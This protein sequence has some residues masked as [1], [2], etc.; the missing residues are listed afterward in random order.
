MADRNVKLSEFSGDVAI[1]HMT[2]MEYINHVEMSRIAGGWTDAVTAEKVKLRLTGAARTWLQN[3]IRAE[4]PGLAA[5]DPPIAN[6]VKPPGL[7]DLMINRFMPQQTAGEQERLRATLIQGENESAQV[8]FDRVESIQFIL[9]LELPEV[10]RRESKAN[11]DIVHN[12][13]VRGSFIA[14]LKQE[15]RKHVTTMDVVTLEDALQ[16][17]VAFEK[18][19]APNKP[20][21]AIS[22]ATGSELTIEARLAALELQRQH[23]DGGGAGAGRGQGKLADEGCFYCGYVGH[24][25]QSCR[26]RQADESRGIFQKRAVGYVP[27]R[28]GRGRGGPQRGGGQQRGGGFQPGRGRGFVQFRGAG[29]YRGGRGGYAHAATEPVY[30]QTQQPNLQ[31]A[32]QTGQVGQPA[33]PQPGF[34]PYHGWQQAP[35]MHSNS[36]TPSPANEMAGYFQDFNGIGAARFGDRSEN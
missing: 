8:F 31:Q 3:R 32:Q 19:R 21:A 23:R 36:S 15:T 7:R 26:I 16:A 12:R 25:K 5:F 10:F 2:V 1:D 22:G 33:V 30:Y 34:Q 18:A 9:D 11:Y 29:Q 4:T 28:V 6:A 35:Q 17:A 20:A 24:N 27:G 14:G 13:Q